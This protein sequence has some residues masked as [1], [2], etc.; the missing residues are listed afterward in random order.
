M[1]MNKEDMNILYHYTTMSTFYN[2]I[3]HSLQYEDG[4]IHPKYITMWATHYAHQND[5]TECQLFFKGLENSILNYARTNKIDITSSDKK[6]IQQPWY[7]LNLFTISFSKQED[8]LTMW[9]GYGQNGNG[10]SLGFDFSKL[11]SSL[12]LYGADC[13][14]RKY[15]CESDPAY[16]RIE[17]LNKCNY[18]DPN[19]IEIAEDAYKRAIENIFGQDK[20]WTD[21]KQAMLI[22][23][24][25]SIYKHY[26][27]E[28][29]G[30]WRIVKNSTISKYRLGENR[31][32]IPYI[33]VN[34]P[35][36]CLSKIIV[37]PC[38]NYDKIIMDIK[39]FLWTKGVKTENMNIIPSSIPYRNRI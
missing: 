11:P 10:I 21:V 39:K 5:P 28:A 4:D 34:V 18:I 12:P 36:D 22:N 26:K 6:L 15:R 14:E 25:A 30:E 7:G 19:K 35:I 8:D 38:Q 27:Y 29:E 17:D 37:G 2:M 1:S 33:E 9:R 24:Y 20:T 13:K 23:K 3:E 16:L 31:S 32:L